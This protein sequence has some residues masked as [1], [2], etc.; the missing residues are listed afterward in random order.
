[1]FVPAQ[2]LPAQFYVYC[3]L[4]LYMWWNVLGQLAT[5]RKVISKQ[6]PLRVLGFT[7]LVLLLLELLVRSSTLKPPQHSS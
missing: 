7:A 4:P 5:L 3:C 6:R 2:S 1:M